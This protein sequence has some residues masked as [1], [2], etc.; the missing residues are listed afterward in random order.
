MA[1]V[2]PGVAVQYCCCAALPPSSLV[3]YSAKLR[4]V[5]NVSCCTYSE[6]ELMCAA[7][8]DAGCRQL[9]QTAI[10]CRILGSCK[11]MFRLVGFLQSNLD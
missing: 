3:H 10:A 8:H 2:P 7:L 6:S 4:L 9:E 5:A 11:T 1:A